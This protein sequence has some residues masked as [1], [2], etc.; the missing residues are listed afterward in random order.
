MGD[1]VEGCGVCSLQDT[2]DGKKFNQGRPGSE[3][4]RATSTGT[5]KLQGLHR[6]DEFPGW[7]IRQEG[8]TKVPLWA[9]YRQYLC[10][11]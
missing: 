7:L 10:L 4:A 11:G 3:L 2:Q 9:Q 1:R 5:A 6:I 8:S